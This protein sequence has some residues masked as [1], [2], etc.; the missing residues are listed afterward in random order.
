MLFIFVILRIE[1]SLKT[2]TTKSREPNYTHEVIKTPNQVSVDETVI[3]NN[4]QQYSLYA[5]VDSQTS[6]YPIIG[7]SRPSKRSHE[8]FVKNFPKNTM[9]TP[10]CSSSIVQLTPK[11][12]SAEQAPSFRLNATEIG[13]ALKI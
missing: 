2:L 7:C 13:R 12:H 8:S 10:V 1:R 5:A 3:H 9:R 6:E 4:D 11:L